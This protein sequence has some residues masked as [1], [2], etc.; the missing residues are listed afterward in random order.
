LPV[1]IDQTSWEC[2]ESIR[3]RGLAYSRSSV[4]L[5]GIEGQLLTDFLVF[6]ASHIILN[7][8]LYCVRT[9][10][11]MVHYGVK[12]ETDHKLFS[13]LTLPRKNAQPSQSPTVATLVILPTLLWCFQTSNVHQTDTCRFH[14][15]GCI[16]TPRPTQQ[17]TYQPPRY[18]VAVSTRLGVSFLRAQ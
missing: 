14:S 12:G 1:P 8:R 3:V 9:L 5:L 4:D 2:R 18:V 13:P 17:R 10:H 16:P 6:G 7:V 11:Y 15:Y